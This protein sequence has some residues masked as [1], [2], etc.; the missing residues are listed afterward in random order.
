VIPELAVS[1]PIA[2]APAEPDEDRARD[3]GV[4]LQRVEGHWLTRIGSIGLLA[5]T[6]WALSHFALAGYRL[7]TDSIVAPL[8]LSK[9][10]DEVVQSK[11]ALSHLLAESESLHVRIRESEMAIEAA[12]RAMGRLEQ[13]RSSASQ[14]LDWAVAITAQQTDLG[15][16]DLFTLGAQQQVIQ[17]MLAGQETLVAEL[18]EFLAKGMIHKAELAREELLLDQLRLSALGNERDRLNNEQQ[19]RSAQLAQRSLERPLAKGVPPTP[20]VIAHQDQLAKLEL[21]VWRLRAEVE[22]K[23]MQTEA[24]ESQLGKLNE[25]VADMKQRPIF[26][27]IDSSQNVAFVPYN[28]IEGVRAGATVLECKW[29]G[30]F[31]CQPAGRV[32]EVVPG[33]VISV[34]PWGM[35]ARGQYAILELS[36]PRAAESRSLR[37]RV[38]RGIPGDS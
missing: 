14:A 25:L 5:G 24:D 3:S 23:R 20:D 9:D 15:A 8:I 2:P 31:Q 11:L 4:E 10:S 26:R 18:R 22:T 19:R 28:Q 21:E 33:E 16:R 13:V 35:Q 36:E 12:T 32:A 34:D 17:R 7:F 1:S 30:L 29:W 38:R 37:V 27:A 6:L